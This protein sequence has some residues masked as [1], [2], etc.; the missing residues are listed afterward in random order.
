M[1]YSKIIKRF[2]NFKEKGLFLTLLFLV[3]FL[4]IAIPSFFTVKN[5]L[6][7]GRQNGLLAIMSLGMGLIII[8]GNIDISVGSIYGLSGVVAAL[9]LQETGYT[10]LALL[11]GLSIG[12]IIGA[13]NG[14]LV[15]K[16]K[17]PSFIATFGMMYVARGVALLITKGFPV[18]L[19]LKGINSDT[20]PVFYFLGQGFLFNKIPIHLIYMLIAFL[21]LSV[22]FHK[23]I[24]G[25]HIY[26]VGGSEKAA[27]VSGIKVKSIRFITFVIV[28]VLSSFA[29][30]SALSYMGSILP[31][32]GTGIELQCIAA[33]LIGGVSFSGGTGS[34]LGVLLGVFILG[35]VKNGL[36]LFGVGSFYEVAIIGIITIFAVSYDSLSSQK[37]K[38]EVY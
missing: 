34:M 6:N 31:T 29:G 18:V 28:G 12:I 36:V 19:L 25:M 37:G 26:A 33:V 8:S 27:Y 30:I 14:F 24:F 16:I 2:L 3:I 38:S 17:M 21:I 5:L 11:S 32:A 22:I 9:V 20:H 13:I 4:M 23:T 1:N 10:L 35:I 7:I 15:E